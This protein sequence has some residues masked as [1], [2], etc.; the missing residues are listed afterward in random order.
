MTKDV[1]AI[2]VALITEME[3]HANL[4][5]AAR[6]KSYMRD[7]YDFYGLQKNERAE[8][9]KPFLAQLWKVKDANIESVV[10]FLWGHPCRECQY[11]AMEYI[12]K[13]SKQWTPQTLTLFEYMITEKSWWDTV[14]MVAST[15]VGKLFQLFPELIQ[16]S[17]KK[18]NLQP[19]FWLHRTSIIFQ[20][21]YADKTDEKL[22]FK[23]CEKN[24]DSKEFFIQKAVGW[25][26]RQHSKL[27]P[28]SVR[29]FVANHKLSTVSLREAK[30]YI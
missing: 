6:M 22:L 28:D 11:V 1:K 10:K 4:F 9:Y 19:D 17:V 21:K 3:A 24:L 25:A 14:D 13:T 8:I 12:T 23:Q 5:Q 26:L 30:K 7:R 20:L 15:F 18:W 27:K 16:P 2:L 29:E